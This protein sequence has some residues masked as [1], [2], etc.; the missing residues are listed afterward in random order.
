MKPWDTISSSPNLTA[1]VGVTVP[2]P[3]TRAGMRGATNRAVGSAAALQG[4]E[5]SGIGHG[6]ETGAWYWDEQPQPGDIR[7]VRKAARD[8]SVRET[9]QENPQTVPYAGPALQSPRNRY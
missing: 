4:I 2:I 6:D 5:R 9:M 3:R 1:P 8:F 7:A